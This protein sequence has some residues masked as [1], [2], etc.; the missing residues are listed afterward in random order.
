M[1]EYTGKGKAA[2]IEGSTFK[3]IIPLPDRKGIVIN[4]TINDTVSDT[5]KERLSKGV[6][7]L[8]K[9]QE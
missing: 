7:L 9:S 5:V 2:F 6:K 8:L 1:K 4:D 3:T